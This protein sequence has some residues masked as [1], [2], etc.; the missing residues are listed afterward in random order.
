MS[1]SNQLPT[2]SKEA[3]WGKN[4]D[5]EFTERERCN[6]GETE[7]QLH[8]LLMCKDSIKYHL[9]AAEKIQKY[10]LS[11]VNKETTLPHFNLWGIPVIIT[12]NYIIYR[13][14]GEWQ[15]QEQ[16]ELYMGMTGLIPTEFT[17]PFNTLI[18][19]KPSQVIKRVN[20]IIVQCA[21]DIWTHRNIIHSVHKHYS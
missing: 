11:K 12:Q 16:I 4:E 1:R 14:I 21:K 17:R 8:A 20:Q 13:T 6:T 9:E 18:F 10:L 5:P 2:L 3:K 7:N 19:K 15:K